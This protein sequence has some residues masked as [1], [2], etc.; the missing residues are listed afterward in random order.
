MMANQFLALSLFVMLL[1]FFLILNSMSNFDD[2]KSR[3]ILNSL[4]VSFSNEKV[5]PDN[6]PNIEEDP[7]DSF[8]EGSTLDRVEALFRSQITGV[9]AE[10][11]RLGTLMHIRLSV[12][13]F[14]K[15]IAMPDA[16]GQVTGGGFM[17]TLVSLLQSEENGVPHRMEMILNIEANPAAAQNETPQLVDEKAKQ[18]SG[19]AEKLAGAGLPEKMIAAGLGQGPDQTIDLYF[20]R[21]EPFNPLG[22]RGGQE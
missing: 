13:K 4:S 10:K 2:T 19:F 9:E 11:N 6:Q 7:A 5:E 12:D 20:R 17:P 22:K 18:V 15:G 8:K 1:S 21:Y 3:P 16:D 14:E